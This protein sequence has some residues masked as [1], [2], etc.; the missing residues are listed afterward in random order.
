M[1]IYFIRQTSKRLE[2]ITYLRTIWHD[3][4]RFEVLFKGLPI[5]GTIVP[6]SKIPALDLEW[7]TRLAV[8]VHK[9][10]T[11]PVGP[12]R[13]VLQR[14]IPPA[15]QIALRIGG[16]EILTLHTNM[17][18]TWHL[19][20]AN[21]LSTG[22]IMLEYGLEAGNTWKIHKDLGDSDTIAIASR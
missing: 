13:P 9:M 14:T 8:Q 15:Q 6:L 22:N 16:R 18:T 2:V 17:F 20:G 3:Q 19:D 11:R 10:W 1:L 12:L 4:F 21:E 5:P 7:R